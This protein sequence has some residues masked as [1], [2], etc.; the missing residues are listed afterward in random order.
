[1]PYILNTDKERGEMLKSIGV[2]SMEELYSHL[3]EGIKLNDGVDLP[4]GLSEFEVKKTLKFLSEKNTPACKINSFLGA[5]CYDHYVPAAVEYILSSPQF[6]TAYT[7]YQAECSQGILQAIYEYQSYIC[8]LTGMD[9]T[10]ASVFDGASALS[11]AV[12]MSMRITGRKKIVIAGVIHPEYKETVKTYLSGFDFSF[13]EVNIGS[14]GDV[15]LEKLKLT[16][17]RDAACYVVQNPNFFGIIEDIKKISDIAKQNRALTIVI[18]NPFSLAILKEPALL[19]ADI[20]CGD[21]QPLGGTMNFGGPSFGFLAAKQDYTRQI[22]GRIVGKTTDSDGAAAYCLTLQTREQHIRREKATSN[23]CS[24]QSLNAIGA[25]V[26]LSLMGKTG[27]KDAAL[28]SFSNAQYLYR[29]L[30]EVRGVKI[31][32]PPRIFNEFAWTV[33]DARKIIDELY[34]KNIVAGYYLGNAFP[35]LKDGILSCCTEK[36]TK[37]EID[38]FVNTMA[39]LLHG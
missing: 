28:S 1:M 27:I 26:Y 3:P 37:E 34:K 17:G 2:K 39:H 7:P 19:G 33:H 16:E 6:L 32:F 10:N 31:L 22:P 38:N 9:V 11:E 15:D 14:R 4:S 12:L 35:G 20:V 25:A 23:I 8:L 21:G 18:T 13:E 29:R 30:G 24:N 36:K 5:G